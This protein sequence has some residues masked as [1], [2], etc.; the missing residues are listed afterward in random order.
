MPQGDGTGPQG[1]GPQTGRGVGPCNTQ[2]QATSNTT[3]NEG[4]F[5]RLRRGL[6]VGRNAQGRGMGRK[7]GRGQGRNR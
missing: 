4:F 1:Q 7:V 2:Q 3:Q 6:G 5:Q